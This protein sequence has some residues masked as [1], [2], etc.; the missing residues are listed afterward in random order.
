MKRWN[1]FVDKYPIQAFLIF[2][3]VCVAIVWGGENGGKGNTPVV[4]QKGIKID[5]VEV[6][7]QGLRAS[8]TAED[9]RI[10]EIAEYIIEYRKKAIMLGDSVITKP[11]DYQWREFARTRNKS[12]AKECWLLDSTFDLRVRTVVQEGSP[13]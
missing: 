12:F 8:W 2:C 10:P 1:Q 11:E 3:F 4:T 9:S 7:P 5:S 13:E 6:T